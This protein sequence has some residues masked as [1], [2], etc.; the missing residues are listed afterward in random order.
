MQVVTAHRLHLRAER[1]A[2]LECCVMSRDTSGQNS[3]S[4]ALT[5]ANPQLQ[6]EVFVSTAALELTHRQ[7]SIKIKQGIVVF[8]FFLWLDKRSGVFL[9][10]NMNK[11]E[12]KRL[13][14]LS[15]VL[16]SSGGRMM[17]LSRYRETEGGG[18]WLAGS[19]KAGTV[20]TL[21]RMLHSA[22]WI[23]QL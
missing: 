14:E 23:L 19:D 6:T 4:T 16:S 1:W 10:Q 17:D 7:W 2:W 9:L 13:Q 12:W 3:R 8:F 15:G 11:S 20:L 18:I 5:S 22:Q 21:S